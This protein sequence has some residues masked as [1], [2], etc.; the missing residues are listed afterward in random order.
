MHWMKK[1]ARSRRVK[2]VERDFH[3]PGRTST[4]VAIRRESKISNFFSSIPLS[5]AAAYSAIMDLENLNPAKTHGFTGW[6][7]S[8]EFFLARSGC[9]PAD[10]YFLSR[11]INDQVLH[12]CF[13][14]RKS[15][16]KFIQ[17]GGECVF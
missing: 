1:T 2:D 15:R 11:F 5:P 12:F 6:T 4:A 17:P 9:R 10:G 8:Q 7:D 14:V 16:Q 3:R 13:Q